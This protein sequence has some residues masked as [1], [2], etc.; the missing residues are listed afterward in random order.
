MTAKKNSLALSISIFALI[1]MG[2]AALAIIT[3]KNY[4]THYIAQVESQ[5]TS[6][7]KLKA[8]EIEKWRSERISDARYYFDNPSFS[9]AIEEFKPNT[10]SSDPNTEI[11]HWFSAITT[12]PEYRD[13]FLLAPDGSLILS[14]VSSELPSKELLAEDMQTAFQTKSIIVKDF[15]K[16]SDEGTVC[17]SILVPVFSTQD[18]SPLGIIILSIDPEVYLYPLILNWPVPSDTAETTLIR[19]EQQHV[20]YLSELKY[21]PDAVLN[22]T[23]ELS[24]RERPSVQA[25]NGAVGI[26]EGINYREQEVIADVR[27]LP[28]TPWF[29]VSRIDKKEAL[30]PIKERSRL[31][32]L[33]AGALIL[34]V[35]LGFGFIVKQQQHAALLADQKIQKEVSET[36]RKLKEAQELAHLGFWY[37]DI[38]SGLVEWSEEV[39]KIFQIDPKTF[40][41]SIDSIMALSPW[42]EEQ[43]R[44]QEL[45]Q[46]AIQT[47]Q[48]GRYEQ[49]FMRPD[50]SIG[51]YSST[52]QGLFDENDQLIAMIG[53][54]LDTTESTEKEIALRESENRFRTLFKHAAIGVLI[55]DPGNHLILDVNQKF[56]DMLGYSRN[57]L[58]K[59]DFIELTSPEFR[60]ISI[61]KNQELALGKVKEYTLEKQYLRKDGQ[62][63]W[64]RV[65]VSPLWDEEETIT[66]QQHIA[67]VNDITQQKK[68]EIAL[69]ESEKKFRETIANLDEGYFGISSDGI[70]C[71]HNPAFSR[72]FG[73]PPQQNL[74]GK[75]LSIFWNNPQDYQN[76]LKK[77]TNQRSVHS[78][79]VT[80]QK[81][82]GERLILL[83]SAHII[84][85]DKNQSGRYEGIFLD[86]TARIDQEE[87]ILATQAE[88]RRLLEEAEQS[89][90]K[91]IKVVE[92]QKITQEEISQLNKTLE[93]R[94]TQRTIELK[95]SNE[96]LESFAY[97]IS[98][99]LRAPLRAIDGYSHI[100][101]QD[102]S[103]VLDEE[104]LRLLSV[105][106]NS[107]KN[108]DKMITDLLSLS[109]VGR[110]ELK[111][112]TIEMTSLVQS[113]FEEL[114]TP[115]NQKTRLIVENI[116]DCRGDPTL[117]RHVWLNLISN[118]LK[119]SAPKDSPEILI[120]GKKGKGFNT[121]TIR[122]NGVGFNPEYREK[123][124]GLFQ[125]L[126]KANEF[127]GTGV[128]LSIVQRVIHRHGGKVWA[129]GKPGEGAEFTFT[130]PK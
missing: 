104:G 18:D 92:E 84:Q 53:S 24:D 75:A 112:A 79:Q 110:S 76:F 57:E 93:D 63:V 12:H 74:H 69:R 56:C 121:Y 78:I 22:V 101:E 98:H 119:Y 118:A 44:D 82:S 29:L 8:A 43:H 28:G 107:T 37:W 54:V 14:V 27:P 106:R 52:F 49:K 45:I 80:S 126:H 62:I 31:I 113:V 103:H 86:I 87:K 4:E 64:G 20:L 33:I 127:E 30:A 47:H 13:L 65:I 105:V 61:K 88:L 17:L 89:K 72:I 90:Q 70:I 9:Q 108:L 34:L 123:L 125:R 116:P 46:R 7:S 42:P 21:L 95:T 109:R 73:Y 11:D 99:D 16:P 71:D 38:K 130:L 3:Y 97:S 25:V 58:L 111:Y 124:F 6:V 1:I 67:V 50:Q 41:P 35:C 122:D 94:V 114:S 81:I 26:V 48:P 100:L 55:L 32:S 10:L 77:L 102:Y 68:V 39:Y 19:K 128:G 40:K 115:E 23:I 60:E 15:Y 129:D 91:L 66:K 117:I 51:Y 36:S 83:V 85:N 5:L 2:I 96:E 59:K 120:T